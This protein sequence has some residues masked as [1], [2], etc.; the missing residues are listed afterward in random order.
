MRLLISHAVEDEQAA[1]LLRELIE[2]CSLKHIKIWFSSD[3]SATGGMELGVSW[4]PSLMKRLSETDAIIA[5]VTPNSVA[6]PWLYFE[7]GLLANKGGLSIIPLSLGMS[8]ADIPLP[9]SAYQAYDLS[10]ASSIQTFLN[11]LFQAADVTFDAEMTL[12]FRERMPPR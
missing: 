12:P 8:V 4:F 9:L 7:C 10:T 11:K 1:S 6:S 5:L 2:R 3:Q